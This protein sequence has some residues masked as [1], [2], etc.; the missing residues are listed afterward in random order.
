[1]LNQFFAQGI[2]IQSEPL[3][4]SRLV[5]VGLYHH[6][7]KQGFF[8]NAN[9]HVVQAVGFTACQIGKVRFKAGA[10]VSLNVLSTHAVFS[11]CSNQGLPFHT[12]RIETVRGPRV[13]V[14]L[15]RFELCLTSGDLIDTAT[16]QI[17]RRQVLGVPTQMFAGRTHACELTVQVV[18]LMQMG[19]HPRAH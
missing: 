17:T 18:V 11:L 16:Q 4:G 9:H 2:A 10:H 7:L 13:K 6:G 12:K 8:D 15:D 1:M 14:G 5:L 19:E 3:G